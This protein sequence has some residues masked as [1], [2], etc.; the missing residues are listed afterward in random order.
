MIMTE[1]RALL[2]LSCF[3]VLLDS[4][5]KKEN[6]L[7]GP[8][9]GLSILEYDSFYLQQYA[10]HK[11]SL[12]TNLKLAFFVFI[13]S[14]KIKEVHILG[15]L[16]FGLRL[17]ANVF[18]HFFLNGCCFGGCLTSIG[19]KILEGSISSGKKSGVVFSTVW[20]SCCI[21]GLSF[22]DLWYYDLDSL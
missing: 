14:N 20:C 19:A 12:L 21:C 17:L 22:L 7:R 3:R 18:L 13:N 16:K 10:K 8:G 15:R 2:M 11:F 9:S 1:R 4:S 6:T 5:P